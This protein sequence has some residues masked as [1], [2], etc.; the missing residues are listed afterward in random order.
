MTQNIQWDNQ[1][2]FIGSSFKSFKLPT[3]RQPHTY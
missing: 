1:I 3:S 2:T